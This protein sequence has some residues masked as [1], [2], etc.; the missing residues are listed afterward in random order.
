MVKPQRRGITVPPP[1]RAEYRTGFV[2]LTD[3]TNLWNPDDDQYKG[4]FF[5]NQNTE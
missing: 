4:I 2:D 5:S 1:S 3:L